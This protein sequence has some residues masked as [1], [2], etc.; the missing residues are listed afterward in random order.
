MHEIK[1]ITL[2][3]DNKSYLF[4]LTDSNYQLWVPF[5]HGY[6]VI[7][8]YGDCQ[9]RYISFLP[10]EKFIGVVSKLLNSLYCNG[11][12]S[13]KVYELNQEED[14]DKIKM[15]ESLQQ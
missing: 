11:S 15:L 10:V 13:T 7:E 3:K 1:D 2:V 8:W 9:P 5:R 12:L 14:I 6:K 4:Q